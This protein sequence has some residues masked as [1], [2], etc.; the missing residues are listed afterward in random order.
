MDQNL[1]RRSSGPLGA[2]GLSASVGLWL[3]IGAVH[4]LV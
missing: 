3:L 4:H 2:F 1:T